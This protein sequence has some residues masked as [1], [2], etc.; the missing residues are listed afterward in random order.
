[1]KQRIVEITRSQYA[2]QV[3]DTVF[4]RPIFQTSDFI[5]RAGIPN[6]MTAMTL[7]RQLRE[8]GELKSLREASGR[9]PGIYAFPNLLNIAEGR[10]AF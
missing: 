7:L 10:E 1:M 2:I 3:L 6:R 8:A 9:R 5:A 4:D